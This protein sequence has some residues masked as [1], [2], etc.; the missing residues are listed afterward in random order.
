M[1]NRNIWIASLS[2]IAF[3]WIAQAVVNAPLA[4]DEVRI[5]D[6]EDTPGG[7]RPEEFDCWSVTGN[8]LGAVAA[9]AG[10]RQTH[11]LAVTGA[12]SAA[13]QYSFPVKPLE[14]YT[15]SVLCKL[16]APGKTTLSIY[17]KTPDGQWNWDAGIAAS[18]FRPF[19]GAWRKAEIQIAVPAE[20]TGFLSVILGAENQG[21]GDAGG[22]AVFDDL[23]IRRTPD[24]LPEPPEVC[25]P[26]PV[27][28]VELTPEDLRRQSNAEVL[29]TLRMGNFKHGPRVPDERFPRV[30]TYE[31]AS[32]LAELMRQQGYNALLTEGQRYLMS[33]SAEHDPYP[34]VLF[35]SLPFPELVEN[36]RM[37]VEAGREQG[38]KMYLHLTML[39]APREMA[40]KHP[41]WMAKDIR[42]GQIREVWTLH[43][44]CMNNPDFA[45]EYFRRLDQLIETVRPDGL[46]V[47]ETSL[48]YTTCG[49][50]HCRAKFLA[51]TGLT[52]P[53]EG[54]SWL[55]R[56]DSDLYRAYMRWRL[57]QAVESNAKIR[58]ALRK[59]V[60]DGILLSYYALPY[61][62]QAIAN[63]GVTIDMAASIAETIGL[64]AISNY[65][66]Y[67]PMY[68]AGMKLIRG[69][70]EAEHDSTD[71]FTIKGF[72]RM[73][74]IYYWWLLGLSQGAHQYWSWYM[75]DELKTERAALVRWECKYQYLT[76]G[77]RAAGETAVWFPTLNNNF[78]IEPRGIINRQNSAFALCANLT[79]AQLPYRVLADAALEKP[80]P[81]T[82]KTLAALNVPML[83]EA[84]AQRLRD[85]V[86]E[87][88]TLVVSAETGLYDE[89][90]H[91][92]DNFVIADLIGAD[93]VGNEGAGA[94]WQN[95][96][97]LDGVRETDEFTTVRPH[98]DA[99]EILGSLERDGR[100][101]PGLLV[102][103][104]GQGRVY[105]WS[106]HP[107]TAIYFAELNGNDFVP[108]DPDWPRNRAVA[109]MLL[110]QLTPAAPGVQTEGLPPGVVVE[111]YE[112]AYHGLDG[113]QVHL[114]NLTAM[115][116]P[117]GRPET[118]N[119]VYP[120]VEN[121]FTVRIADAAMVQGV[122]AFSP[123]FRDLRRVP[124]LLDA[125]GISVRIPRLEH[126]LVLY[127][128]R[129]SEAEFAEKV[130]IS[131]SD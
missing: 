31:E 30:S 60:P 83:S 36:T 26:V 18:R 10:Y 102:N 46:M 94:T 120:P 1:R 42:D 88:G 54:D 68:I 58:A 106:G 129:I 118:R 65:H 28:A 127:F 33:D 34:D 16:D 128:S 56:T 122:Y 69:A 111:S 109:D 73:V 124:F 125:A 24:A 126:Y 92:R 49:C 116:T 74:D 130:E 21:E 17:W 75:S 59:H 52:M 45:M 14:R 90:F 11:G 39:A 85:F 70:A 77:L 55:E 5:V 15:V 47:D 48:M 51:D 62:E 2:L 63:H 67:W 112:H 32:R 23:I 7:S 78:N 72:A 50:V 43:W 13:Y 105:Y 9:G 96:G 117:D 76:A 95:A 6:F 99:A 82:V 4:G 79:L 91:K 104:Y 113:L 64:E 61:N 38:M 100:S 121:E 8:P 80:I 57:A 123:D 66:R 22:M 25:D 71:I 37:A 41:E 84:Q 115:V 114:M 107:E 93:Y 12:Q 40:Q 103:R 53:P 44:L 101:L 110:A 81:A 86:R 97:A 20:G 29:H 108:R 98:P 87:G 89:N 19:D 3:G 131:I 119:L 27:V 35:A